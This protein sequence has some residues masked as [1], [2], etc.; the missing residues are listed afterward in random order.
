[1]YDR[2]QAVLLCKYFIEMRVNVIILYTLTCH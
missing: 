1:M 2:I